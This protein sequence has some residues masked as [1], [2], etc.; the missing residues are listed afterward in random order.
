MA[1]A[2]LWVSEEFFVA[3][4]MGEDI[5]AWPWPEG[6]IL[7]EDTDKPTMTMGNPR[8]FKICHPDIPEGTHRVNP[9][10]MLV[11]ED[12]CEFVEW[13]PW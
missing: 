2:K 8:C 6:T 13:R 5:E 3:N 7:E 9:S 10:W 12:K 1:C 11:G 4:M